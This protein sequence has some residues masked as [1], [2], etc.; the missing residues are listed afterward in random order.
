MGEGEEHARRR[1]CVGR[2]A[3]WREK[4]RG[5]A[6]LLEEG[7]F[8]DKDQVVSSGKIWEAADLFWIFL[9]LFL[10]SHFY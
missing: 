2:N 1:E 6:R 9:F 4:W 8:R 3:G 5:S 10:L 7:A